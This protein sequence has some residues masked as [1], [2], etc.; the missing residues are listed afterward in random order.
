MLKSSPTA[1]RAGHPQPETATIL[2]DIFA[3]YSKQATIHDTCAPIPPLP[4]LAPSVCVLNVTTR[5]RH[6]P[7]LHPRIVHAPGLAYSGMS[8]SLA[9]P[10][11][12]PQNRHALTVDAASS[13]HAPQPLHSTRRTAPSLS[14]AVIVFTSQHGTNDD[15]IQNSNPHHFTSLRQGVR[16]HFVIFGRIDVFRNV[17]MRNDNQRRP[18]AHRIFEHIPRTRDCFF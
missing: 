1:F 8:N 12:P 16:Q 15:M 17:I 2:P 13:P 10:H 5:V 3:L 11:A 4:R 7:P 18:L 6:I 14:K 9:N